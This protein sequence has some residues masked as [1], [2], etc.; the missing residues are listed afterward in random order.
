MG[1]GAATAVLTL[2]ND[3]AWGPVW[4]CMGSNAHAASPVGTPAHPTD[5]ATLGM[6]GDVPSEF[7]LGGETAVG[8]LCGLHP[9]HTLAQLQIQGMPFFRVGM[10]EHINMT[11]AKFEGRGRRIKKLRRRPSEMTIMV[12]GDCG[13]YCLIGTARRR[14]F[15]GLLCF[16]L[17]LSKMSRLR[18]PGCLFHW[19]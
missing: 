19:E 7:Q 12:C 18:S 3:S 17:L 9:L 5:W 2:E 16:I 15:R 1:Q 11:P 6:H 8:G 10:A 4:V 13:N 14:L